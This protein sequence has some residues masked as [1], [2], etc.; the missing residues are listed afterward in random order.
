MV[1]YRSV[2]GRKSREEVTTPNSV[3]PRL[4]K[5]NIKGK[6]QRACMNQLNQHRVQPLM[7]I[8]RSYYVNNMDSL[9][10]LAPRYWMSE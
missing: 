7:T 4:L 1:Q 10:L 6:P 8:R 5:D 3:S 9:R 2:E